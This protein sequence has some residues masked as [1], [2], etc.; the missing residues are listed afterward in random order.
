[1]ARKHAKEQSLDFFYLDS[2]KEEKKKNKKNRAK[3]TRPKSG[4]KKKKQEEVENDIFDFDNEIVIG[5]NVIPEPKKDKPIK[6][7]KIS[8]KQMKEKQEKKKKQEE[9][10]KKPTKGKKEEAKRKAVPTKRVPKLTKEQQEKIEKRKR[11][12]RFIGKVIKTMLAISI[13]VAAIIFFLMSP[14]FNITEVLVSGNEKI[15]SEE[16][17]SLSKITTGENTYKIIN[18]RVEK[19]VKENAYIETVK[20][21]RKLPNKIEITVKERHPKYMLA[22]GNAF[23]YINSQGYMLEIAETPIESPIIDG[24]M[25]KE[26]E[27]KPGN[28]LNTEDLEKLDTVLKIMEAANSNEIA[29]MITHIDITDKN[30]YILVLEQQG[31]TVYLGN[32]SN[33]NDRMLLLKEILSLEEGNSGEVFLNDINN[34]FFRK[35]V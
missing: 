9:Q 26:E 6:K 23:V 11:R 24:Y 18:S 14:M 29:K 1:M 17:I 12:N 10:K 31:K 27:I 20:M 5:V 16:I 34:V 32:A 21:K 30:N 35:K 25:T 33:I 13:L 4:A 7:K 19:N 28:R 2:K 3:T 15:G 22:F 8:K